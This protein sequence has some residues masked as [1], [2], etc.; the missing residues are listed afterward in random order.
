MG[1]VVQGWGQASGAVRCGAVGCGGGTPHSPAP[2]GSL[3][4]E[5]QQLNWAAAASS[6]YSL[7]ERHRLGKALHRPFFKARSLSPT[8]D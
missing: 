2:L 7:S 1:H 3:C 6:H 4:E 5:Q 8:T